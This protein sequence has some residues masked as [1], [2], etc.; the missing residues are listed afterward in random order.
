MT[1]RVYRSRS[2]QNLSGADVHKIYLRAKRHSAKVVIIYASSHEDNSF[3]VRY[4]D[5]TS[6]LRSVYLPY[7]TR[8]L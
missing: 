3:Y 6:V 8:I 2:V 1:V 7:F 5:D 4:Y